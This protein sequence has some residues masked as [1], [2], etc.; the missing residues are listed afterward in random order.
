MLLKNIFCFCFAIIALHSS[1]QDTLS[2]NYKSLYL[3]SKSYFLKDVVTVQ[4][5]LVVAPGASLFFDNAVTLVCNGFVKLEGTNSERINIFSAE[6]NWGAGLVIANRSIGDVVIKYVKFS[7]LVAP[8]NFTNGWSRNSIDISYCEFLKNSGSSAIVRIMDPFFPVGDDSS[9]VKCTITHCLFA[10]N[11]ASI[12]FEDFN[13][14]H[15]SAVIS[16]NTFFGNRISGYGEYSFSGNLFY[17]RLDKVIGN[18]FQA[19][20][21]NNSFVNN[22]LWDINSDTA[23]R[24]S[25]FGIYGNADSLISQYN[26]WGSADSSKIPEGIYDYSVNY[27]CPKLVHLPFS[28]KPDLA[29]PAH[30]YSI[31]NESDKEIHENFSLSEGLSQVNLLSNKPVDAS[32]LR[33][34]F[35]YLKD[36]LTETVSD[37]L[38]N[39]KVDSSSSQSLKVI[40]T[41]DS[42]IRKFSGY[43]TV[44]QVKGVNSETVPEVLIGFH[45]FSSY[46]FERRRLKNLELT[47]VIRDSSISKPKLPPVIL[48]K[49]KKK[50]ELG[51][52]GAFAIYYGT[53]SNK[54]LFSNDFNS[55]L[56]IQ[57][58][59]S[60]QSH[61]S[62][63]ASFLK[64]TL[65][66]A[67]VRSGDSSKIIR[68]MSFKT[69]VTAI[70][71]QLEY[72]VVDNRTYSSRNRIRPSIGFG[73]DYIKFNPLGEYLGTLYPLQP[74]GTGGQTLDSSS[75]KQYP[76]SSFGAPLTMQLRYCLNKNTIFSVFTT[77]HLTFT[78]YLDDV[79]P[80]P[81]PDQL[82]VAQINGVNGSAAAYFSNPTNRV[83]SKGQ[84]RSGFGSSSDGFFTLGFSLV[85]HF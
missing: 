3:S 4:D 18:S 66:G 37:T 32:Q 13:S 52:V 2:G 20:I 53:L 61:I 36:S 30:F 51:F 80:T 46:L 73:L 42:L 35:S 1:A 26:F 23:V 8:L 72:D 59:Y 70:S 75:I 69:P 24:Q 31:L 45:K 47:K 60:L 50:Y 54:K 17:G 62:V 28:L 21:T 63:S 33:V 5:S 39:I 57:F 68:G 79:G 71:L 27:T 77:Y 41:A 25:N 74:L 10:Y 58:R 67:D 64:T 38:L 76:L 44:D 84:L 14:R 83:V 85:H 55:L 65:T 6:K 82:K 48:T 12:Y 11:R 19:K 7:D 81:Y 78:D 49:F 29:L 40:L 16:E 22:Y 15:L 56:G 43:L 9:V 34:V